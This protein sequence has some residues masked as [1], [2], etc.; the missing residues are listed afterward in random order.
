MVRPQLAVGTW[1]KIRVEE[2]SY[3][4]ADGKTKAKW[5]ARGRFRDADGRTRDV[6]RISLKSEA[7]ARR[8]LTEAFGNR[9]KAT[10]SDITTDTPFTV[11]AGMWIDEITATDKVVQQTREKYE[12]SLKRVVIPALGGLRLGEISTGTADRFLKKVASTAPGNA[13]MARVVLSGIMDLAVRHDAIK[14]NPVDKAAPIISAATE[15][16]ALTFVELA[17]LRARIA[18]WQSGSDTDK[19]KGGRRRTQD[20]LKIVDVWVGTAIRLGELCA[21]RWED[22]DLDSVPATL[23][24]NGT[25]VHHAGKL[26]R[27]EHGKSS[28]AR[29]TVSL[30]QFTVT[31]LLEL[32][33][34]ATTPYV[35]PS[36][37]G[38]LRD[39]HNLG[40]QWR[41][42]RGEEFDWVTPKAFRK[43]VA[44]L[45]K[46]EADIEA[47]ASQLGHA[48]T[49]VTKKHYT[50]QTHRAP[51]LS[52]LLEKLAPAS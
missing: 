10:G 46:E 47:A 21:L 2:L 40:R 34:T 15:K 38:T 6:E 1:G 26:V 50:V 30:P 14:I 36:S 28:S 52:D 19:A 35:F 42:A 43:T 51:D 8:A 13:R 9:A 41:A 23:T 48:D 39:P 45:I 3:T 29:R 16:R 7:A 11:C 17:R 24:V 20:L 37:T 22:V 4:A 12:D 44:T 18:D 32:R 49:R 27:Q 31:T 25:N 5:R 33:E